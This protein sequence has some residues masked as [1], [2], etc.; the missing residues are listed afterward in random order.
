M[1]KSTDVAFIARVDPAE[2]IAMVLDAYER[3][4]G[5]PD[6]AA[7]LLGYTTRRGRDSLH[8]LNNRLG[9]KHLVRQTTGHYPGCGHHY[10]GTGRHG[11]R[12]TT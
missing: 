6:G 10:R 9:I 2:A 1:R 5:Y 3:A 8:K 12:T 7:R 4:G 11:A